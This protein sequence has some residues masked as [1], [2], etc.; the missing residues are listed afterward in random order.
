[1]EKLKQGSFVKIGIKCVELRNK[2]GKI[3]WLGPDEPTKEINKETLEKLCGKSKI[4]VG[5]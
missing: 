1:L 3:D 4:L 2:T 5:K